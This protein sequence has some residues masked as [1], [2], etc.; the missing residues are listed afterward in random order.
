MARLQ[1]GDSNGQ[2]PGGGVIPT[3]YRRVPCPKVGNMYLWLRPNSN[4]FWFSF[5][6]VNSAEWGGVVLVEVKNTEGKW[7]KFIRDPN[8]SSTRPQERYGCGLLPLKL[9]SLKFLLI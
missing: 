9:E 4:E 5:N 1:T 3:K 8:Y 6:I 7:V 2:L